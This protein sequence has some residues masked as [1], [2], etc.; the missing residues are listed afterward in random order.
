MTVDELN[1]IISAKTDG[2][3]KQISGVKKQMTGFEKSVG[4]A[5]AKI[6]SAFSKI[7]KAAIAAFSVKAIVDFGKQ[8]VSLA[9]DLQEVQNVVDTAFGDMSGKVDEWAKTTVDKFG[10]SELAAKQAASAYM[11]MSKGMGMAGE[12][13]AEMAMKAAERTGDIA[14]FYNMSQ[15]EAD[16]MMKSIWTGETESL[17]RIGVVMTQTNL[18]AY[19]LANGFGKTTDAMSQSEQVMLRYQYVMEQ[20]G[21]AA[22]DFQKTSGS[23][24]NQVRVLS[25]RFKE[26]LAVLGSGLLQVLTPVVQ[27]LNAVLE[28]LVQAATAAGQMISSMFGGNQKETQDTAQNVQS[29]AASMGDLTKQT[30]AA[31]KA[32]KGALAGFDELNVLRSGDAQTAESGTAAGVP[33]AS[34]ALNIPEPDISGVKGAADKVKGIFEDLG[35]YIS[36][37]FSPTFSSWGKALNGLKAPAVKAFDTIKGSLSGLWNNTLKPAGAYLATDFIPTVSN[38]FSETFAPIFGE[39]MPVLFEEFA[40]DFDFACAEFDRI[41]QDILSPAFEHVK[42]VAVGVFS[43]IKASWDEHG[44]GILDGFQGFKERAREIW[45]TVYTN[46]FKPVFDRVAGI[47]SWLWDKH[48]KPLWDNISDFIGSAAEFLLNLWNEVLAPIVKRIVEWVGP[49]ITNIIGF[50]GDVF[51]TVFG[52]IA[53]VVGGFLKQLSGIM[54]FLTGIFTGNWEK[55]WSGIEKFVKGT[56]DGIW[57]IIK[58]VVNLIIDG[59]NALWSGI[60]RVA[61]GIVNGLGSLV[62]GFGS[63]FGQDWGFSMPKEPPLIPKLATGGLA[64]GPTLAMIGEGNDREAVLPLNADV[65]G[66]LARGIQAAGGTGSRETIT[67]LERILTAIEQIDPT[68]V[69]DGTT[70]ARSSDKYFAAEQRR[71][72]PSL[73]KV[74]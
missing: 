2:L 60:Y 11:A 1:V 49:Q 41:S 46:V 17:K 30:A 58:G 52:V 69:M 4:Q 53:D 24:A 21:L 66:E 8:A 14:S 18:D 65:Y 68:M 47:V 7:G 6:S 25:E 42:G 38:A 67:L 55:A 45:D 9:S 28:K 32:A 40:A 3:N 23:W 73:V 34:M 59:L 31:G 27:F 5:N 39:T 50:I 44:Q 43:G 12:Q 33:A 62:E 63:L 51:G 35:K 10:V 64:Y 70:L 74:V 36:T 22:G 20:T 72:G 57:G 71:R 48:L 16:T 19:A 37:K 54:D 26:L 13:A 29:A 56:W 15:Q 61:S